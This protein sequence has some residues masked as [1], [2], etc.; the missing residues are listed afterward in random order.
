MFYVVILHVTGRGG[1]RSTCNSAVGT[2][3]VVF[4][5]TIC[6]CAVNCYALISGYVGYTNVEKKYRYSRY[7]ETWLQAVFYGVLGSTTFLIISLDVLY[8][9]HF[10]LAFFPVTSEQWWYFIQ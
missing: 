2:S 8:L 3:I 10:I 4:M 1:V 9:K 7:I 5:R 6:F